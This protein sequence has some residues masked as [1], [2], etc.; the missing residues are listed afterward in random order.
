[1]PL[2]SVILPTYN[3]RENIGELIYT[4][5]KIIEPP[6]EIIVVDDDSPDRTWEVVAALQT[7]HPEVRL[8]RRIG[9]RG[10]ATAVAEGVKNSRGDI[11]V[12]MDCDFSHPPELIP[13]LIGALGECDITI[14]SR[15]VS[16][17]G[18]QAPWLRILASRLIDTFASLLL[19]FSVKDWTSGF[20]AVRRETMDKVRIMPL[21]KGYGEYFIAFLFE[22]K[23]SGFKIKEI[24]YTCSYRRKG[25]T[26]TSPSPFRL[27]GYGLSYCWCVLY[28]RGK[29]LIKFTSL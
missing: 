21:G 15:W 25:V 6:S 2:V 23:E 27:L 8:I 29:N 12:W 24:P 1:M 18:I 5:L 26:K 17:G 10:L 22:G 16:G 13:R 28:L 4:I 7:E 19:G 14:A 11:L 3:E 20:I 9:E